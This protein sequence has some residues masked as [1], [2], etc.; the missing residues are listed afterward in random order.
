[1]KA[2]KLCSIVEAGNGRRFDVEIVRNGSQFIIIQR[3]DPAKLKDNELMISGVMSEGNIYPL[4]L[5]EKNGGWIAFVGVEVITLAVIN[6]VV[7]LISEKTG[8]QYQF[9]PNRRP[10]HEP[11]FEKGGENGSN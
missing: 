10:G 8:I 3:V 7:A 6:F 4:I 1:M 5:Q 2:V 11:P 9:D